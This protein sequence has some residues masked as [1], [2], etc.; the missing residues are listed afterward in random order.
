MKPEL[1][2]VNSVQM[3]CVTVGGGQWKCVFVD[4]CAICL[5]PYVDIFCPMF[6]TC[7][8]IAVKDESKLL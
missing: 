1:Y 4:S 2:A 8:E 3:M 7:S 5:M 6:D